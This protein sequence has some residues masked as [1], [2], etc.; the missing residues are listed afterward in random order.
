MHNFTSTIGE[1]CYNTKSDGRFSRECLTHQLTA[2]ISNCWVLCNNPFGHNASQWIASL[3]FQWQKQCLSVYCLVHT[4]GKINAPQWV[5]LS[6]TNGKSNASQWI[7]CLSH[8]MAKAMPLSEYA[9][10]IPMAKAMPLSGLPSTFQWQTN[11]SQWVCLSHFNGKSNASQWVCLSHIPMVKAQ[12]G[13]PF[14]WLTNTGSCIVHTRNI[15]HTLHVFRFI[16]WR[17]HW[18]AVVRKRVEQCSQQDLQ[19]QQQQLK[20]FSARLMWVWLRW[21]WTALSPFSISYLRQAGWSKWR[22][23]YRTMLDPSGLL[24][25]SI[26]LYNN[27]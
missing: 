4:N 19:Q 2:G 6:H 14:T 22:W 9:S 23:T 21:R 7:A 16:H 5:C 1:I 18:L 8:S 10:H 27:L 3:T 26:P 12:Q 20:P 17:T 13:I 25:S 15:S 24:P 11:A